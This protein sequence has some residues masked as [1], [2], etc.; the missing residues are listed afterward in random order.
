MTS[1]LTLY[2]PP[3]DPSTVIWAGLP[4]SP[5]DALAKYDVDAVLSTASLAIDSN[6]DFKTRGT[7]FGIANQV[8][9][10]SLQ[11]SFHSVN[12]SQVKVAIEECR[13]IKDSYEIALIRKANEVTTSA[14]TAALRAVKHVSNE[15]ELEGLF[16]ERCFAGGCRNQAYSSIVASGINAATLHYVRNDEALAGRL[17]LLL[18]AGAEYQ[19]YAADVTRTFPI[20]GVF[21]RESRA[22]Y[23]LVL[24]MQES[25]IQLLK[26]G[27]VWDDVHAHAHKIAIEGLLALG[28]F[29]GDAADIFN[30]RTSVAFFPHGLGHYLGMDTHDTGGNA[31]YED[32]DTMYKYLRV[33]GSLPAGSVI[34]VEPG[35]YFCRFI[36]EPYLNHEIHGKFIDKV[37]LDKYWNVGGVRIEG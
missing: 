5:A 33:R 9:N 31:N 24:K 21:T 22:I 19:C 18:D 13:V 35:I 7:F 3:V 37:V 16:V 32:E 25:C 6:D 11:L 14:H 1:H 36:L 15:R 23:D 30:T 29:V 10:S 17:N 12:L 2:I 27:V 20:S 34:T 28:I 4:V 26:G 8:S